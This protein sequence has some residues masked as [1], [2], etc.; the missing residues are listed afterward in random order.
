MPVNSPG[1]GSSLDNPGPNNKRPR[2]D[3]PAPFLT[4]NPFG[5]L[6][7]GD[8]STS[9]QMDVANETINKDKCPPLYIYNINNINALLSEINNLNPGSFSYRTT[10]GAIRLTTETIDGYR[11]ITSYL[12]SKKAEFHT[13]QLKDNRN[14]RVVIRGLHHTTDPNSI[15]S[16]LREKHGFDPVQAIPAI[17]PATKAPMPIF[18]VDLKPLSKNA[19]IYSLQR[20]G[21]AVIKVEPPKPK[22]T[23]I[24]CTKCQ[25]YGHSKN[26][27]HRRPKCVKC[28]GLHA[29]ESCPKQ[30]NLPPVCTNCKG[31]HTA[32]YKGCP[33]HVNLQKQRKYPNTTNLTSSKATGTAPQLP[34]LDLDKNHFPPLPQDNVPQLRP[35]LHRPSY[36]QAAASPPNGANDNSITSTLLKKIDQLIGLLQPMITL[37]T[38]LLPKLIK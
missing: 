6:D 26:Y 33:I 20:L 38:Q 12:E 15:I 18:F 17:H 1:D 14:F 28:D 36:S 37:L 13:Y 19:E 27:C 31:N 32:N 11:T 16:E 10:N 8:E 29:T 30:A 2:L 4:P 3:Q 24:Q 9:N 34:G 5:P 25:S 22:K 35:T 7:N 23:V 21:N